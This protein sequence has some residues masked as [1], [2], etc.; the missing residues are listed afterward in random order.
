LCE[1]YSVIKKK[2]ISIVHSR[3]IF[4]L[5]NPLEHGLSSLWDKGGFATFMI[6]LFYI[7]LHDYNNPNPSS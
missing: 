4:H 3:N 2:E 5:I 6:E 1:A 7:D